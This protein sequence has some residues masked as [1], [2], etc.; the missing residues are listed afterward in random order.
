MTVH[1][2]AG[3]EDRKCVHKFQCASFCMLPHVHSGS[4]AEI[5]EGV[6]TSTLFVKYFV[7]KMYVVCDKCS[8]C[9]G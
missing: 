9:C 7:C 2:L 5:Q 1:L 6:L 8:L 4:F 3:H